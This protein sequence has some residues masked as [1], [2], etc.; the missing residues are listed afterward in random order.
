LKSPVS[1]RFGFLLVAPGQPYLIEAQGQSADGGRIDEANDEV[2][3]L[4]PI[5]RRP[6]DDPTLIP[7]QRKRAKAKR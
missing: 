7:S 2:Q 3:V 6:V 5:I 1:V 4:S